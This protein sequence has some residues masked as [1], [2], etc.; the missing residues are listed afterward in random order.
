M[1]FVWILVAAFAFF[2]GALGAK[3][4]N[5]VELRGFWDDFGLESDS[6]SSSSEEDHQKVKT[7][8]MLPC[9]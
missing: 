6:S 7:T 8:T 4:E 9:P 1:R 5:N 2:L 3:A